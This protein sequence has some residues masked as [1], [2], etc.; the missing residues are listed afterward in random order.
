LA[1]ADIEANIEA[2]IEAEADID[3]GIEADRGMGDETVY[4]D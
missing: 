4:L 3:G 1:D 2:G